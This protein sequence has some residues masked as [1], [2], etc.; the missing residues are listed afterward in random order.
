MFELLQRF[1]LYAAIPVLAACS[2]VTVTTDFDPSTAFDK[3]HTYALQESKEGQQLSPSSEKAFR[4]A[5]HINLAAHGIREATDN[6]DLSVLRYVST[7]E[8]TVVYQSYGF[9]YDY[10]Y[11]FGRY[12]AW[13]GVPRNYTDVS[14]YTEGTLIIDFVD[15]KTRKLVFRG[16]GKGTL[17]DPQTNAQR[18]S[19]A[20]QKIILEFPK[21]NSR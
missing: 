17:G 5:I 2:A 10:G 1:A 14:Q 21:S 7:K 15:A 20:V 19:E 16:I 3:Y 11:G 12:G 8:K 9:G 4:D 6:A 18:I 13:T